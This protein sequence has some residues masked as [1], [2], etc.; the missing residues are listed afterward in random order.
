MQANY[1]EHQ[2]KN[3]LLS[4]KIENKTYYYSL[5]KKEQKSLSFLKNDRLLVLNFDDGI[6]FYVN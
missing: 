6:L 1:S 4:Q 2:L 3:T 5:A